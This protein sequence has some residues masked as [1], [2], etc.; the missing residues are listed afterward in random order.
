MKKFTVT[1]GEDGIAD[2]QEYLRN[3]KAGISQKADR[4]ID[5]LAHEAESDINQKL[6]FMELDDNARG[7]VTRKKM[8]HKTVVSHT[9]SDVMFLEFGTGMVGRNSPHP[10]SP[11]YSWDYYIDTMFK[12]TTKSGKQGWFYKHKFRV[13]IPAGR[14]V[15][16]A[17][18]NAHRNALKK[19]QEVFK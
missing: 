19:A 15:Y 8:A 7:V 14:A 2:M 11:Q 17:G 10:L 5:E 18:Q 9:G 6:D 4:V 1:F 13:G 12:K 3:L 16:N